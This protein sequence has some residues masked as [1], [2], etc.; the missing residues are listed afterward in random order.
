MAVILSFNCEVA[1]RI[2]CSLCGAEA[3]SRWKLAL[4]CEPP[5]P[6]LPDHWRVVDGN[7]VCEKH[8]ITI[9]DI[10]PRQHGRRVKEITEKGA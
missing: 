5:H 3:F 10:P 4:G 8:R 9:E 2:A 1:Y 6:S 7:V